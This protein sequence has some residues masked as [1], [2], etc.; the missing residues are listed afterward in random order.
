MYGQKRQR[1]K[2]WKRKSGVKCGNGRKR[3]ERRDREIN[4][5]GV[6]RLEFRENKELEEKRSEWIVGPYT[7]LTFTR[8]KIQ[9]ETKS[10]RSE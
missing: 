8:R 3:R 5:N 6:A 10:E 2:R 4:S 7:R 9:G 1:V